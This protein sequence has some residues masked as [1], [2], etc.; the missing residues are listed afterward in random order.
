MTTPIRRLLAGMSAVALLSGS[1][2]LAADPPEHAARWGL[3]WLYGIGDVSGD[4]GNGLEKYKNID[5]EL[6]RKS[7][8]GG[9]RYGLGF[10]FGSFAMKP[11][12]ADLEEFG[13]M[14]TYLTGAKVFRADKS[15]RPYLELQAGVARTHPRSLLFAIR[16]VPEDLQVGDS[17][18]EPKNGF[19]VALVPGV[20]I[21]INRSFSVD[22][23]VQ[24]DAFNTDEYDLTPIGQP[25]ASSGSVIA[26]RLGF[27]WVPNGGGDGPKDAFGVPRSYGWALGE[28]LAINHVASRRNEYKRNAN[29]NQISPRS[30]YHNI[31]HGFDYD[32]NEFRTNQLQ[33]P[34]NGSTYYNSARANGI[35]FWTSSAYALGGAF[36][37]ECC[38][39]THPMSF[40]DMVSTG[41][42]GIALGEMMYRMSSKILD[43]QATGG[44]HIWREAAAF[45]V[46]PIRG[47]NRLVSGRASRQYDNPSDPM[48]WH[49]PGGGSFLALG[50]RT[51]GRGES[52]SENTK[53]TGYFEFT[54]AFGNPFDN[55][56][57]RPYDSF[58]LTLQVNFGDKV[59]LG[60]AQVV[61]S[62]YKKRLGGDGANHVL[63][64]AQHYDYMNNTDYEFGGQSFGPSLLSRFA[65]GG[66]WGLR[67]RVDGTVMLLG[68]INSEYAKIASV[69]DRERLR[70][71]DYGPG[72]GAAAEATLFRGGRPLL[73]A[74]YR[75]Q[76]IN[77]SNGSVY[78]NDQLG[79]SSS[80]EHYIQMAGVRLTIPLYRSL[81]VG[82]DGVMFF[83]K[84]RYSLPQF[85][86]ID[87]RNP[88]ARVYLTVNG[89]R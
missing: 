72:L 55:E 44:E 7:P 35:G 40:N 10:G 42:G 39:E 81:G 43:N 68:A 71:Y 79:I 2:A 36:V 47:F 50:A 84:S 59:P 61:G 30:F 34:F 70:E 27:N 74:G 53:T 17:P 8:K 67:T 83:R 57:N 69:N 24:F 38:G 23:S 26:A 75:F 51:I 16:P 31:S 12:Y 18:T 73:Q 21:S 82:G 76:W 56:R 49:V 9:W 19:M 62:L 15:I 52:I 63:E 78:N 25:P 80:A 85:M 33:H 58:D 89:V 87:Q 46:D 48:D 41:I 37:W 65:L 5:Y 66:K 1:T 88:Q 4:Y 29:F 45:L 60:Q 13:L 28:V 11:P 6:Y 20:E 77:V 22:A 64:I 86:D 54:H 32:D 3:K 14:R